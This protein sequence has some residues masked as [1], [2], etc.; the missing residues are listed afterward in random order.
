KVGRRIL[1]RKVAPAL[2]C[3]I[4]PRTHRHAFRVE[5]EP[6]AADPLLIGERTNVEDALAAK[7]FAADHPVDRATAEDF[8]RALGHHARGVEALRL[9]HAALLLLGKLQLDP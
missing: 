5:N 6:A 9:L 1:I 3:A 8:F 4:R 2:E 7:D